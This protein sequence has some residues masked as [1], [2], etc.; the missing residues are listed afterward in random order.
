MERQVFTCVKVF[1]RAL[2]LGQS[3]GQVFA[4]AKMRSRLV[5]SLSKGYPAGASYDTGLIAKETPGFS[6]GSFITLTR[7]PIANYGINRAFPWGFLR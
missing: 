2:Y 7:D 3:E 5:L 4:R 1:A 6:P